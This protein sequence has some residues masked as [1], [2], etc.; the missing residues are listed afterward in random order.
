MIK[1]FL[2]VLVEICKKYPDIWWSRSRRKKIWI[3]SD[4]TSTISCWTRRTN[5]GKGICLSHLKRL[6]SRSIRK[7]LCKK[8]LITHPRYSCNTRILSNTGPMS[9]G[10]DWSLRNWSAIQCRTRNL[11]SW[12]R[13]A[14][15]TSTLWSS[16]T[17]T[18]LDSPRA[19]EKYIDFYI[20]FFFLFFFLY[21][22]GI[23]TCFPTR[24]NNTLRATPHTYG[25]IL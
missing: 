25:M 24:Y 23:L 8:N 4:R 6:K 16:P 22:L 7:K 3:G 20:D 13:A 19:D 21:T 1:L 14:S 12:C 10:F 2:Y 5:D 18:I 11:P 17:T 9:T 15:T